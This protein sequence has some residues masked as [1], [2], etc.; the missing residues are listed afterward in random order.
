MNLEE[1]FVHLAGRTQKK[2]REIEN[3]MKKD[4][5]Q[6]EKKGNNCFVCLIC[7]SCLFLIINPSS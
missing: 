5:K 6:K 2:R 7:L 1:L 4:N 3:Y